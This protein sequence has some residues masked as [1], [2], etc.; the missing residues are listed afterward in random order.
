MILSYENIFL[1]K[2]QI[3]FAI[4]NWLRMPDFCTLFTKISID[5]VDFWPRFCIPP[6]ESWSPIL[7]YL[8]VSLW[9]TSAG[10]MVA[11]MMVLELPPSES[12]RSH[13]STESRYGM[14]TWKEKKFCTRGI[15]VK[16]CKP[17]RSKDLYQV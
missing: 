12:L 17:V 10:L 2:I 8:R 9:L 15:I 1:E 7:P 3:I 5:H 4:E 6:M 16:Q 11:I 13:V 14:K